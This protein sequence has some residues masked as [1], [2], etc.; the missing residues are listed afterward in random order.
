VGALPF[1][2]AGVT[3][4][5][6]AAATA[7]TLAGAAACSVAGEPRRSG[8]PDGALDDGARATV[9]DWEHEARKRR[10]EADAL[11]ALV[12]L[13]AVAPTDVVPDAPRL[14][15]LDD[16]VLLDPSPAFDVDGHRERARRAVAEGGWVPV[17]KARVIV[18][19]EALRAPVM[20]NEF[21]GRCLEELAFVREV[22]LPG[23]RLAEG[24]PDP[25]G[26]RARK[27][28]QPASL[29][30]AMPAGAS[31]R[32]VFRILNCATVADVRKLYFLVPGG[33]VAVDLERVPM[34]EE[35]G[36]DVVLRLDDFDLTEALAE[37]AAARRRARERRRVPR[38]ALVPRP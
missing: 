21:F 34:L 28:D 37:V 33:A 2:L 25:R 5:A 22:S 35:N 9:A 6:I 29:A 7:V 1:V 26:D 4:A 32:E 16:V 15:V 12:P 3:G 10:A 19:R 20:A 23:G 11:V 24:R 8:R 13:P 17:P 27:V 38:V 31:H 36:F 14:V 30:V 18:P